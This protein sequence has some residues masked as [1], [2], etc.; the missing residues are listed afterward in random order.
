MKTVSTLLTGGLLLCALLATPALAQAP[1][2]AGQYQVVRTSQIKPGELEL[3][4]KATRDNQAWYRAHG[5]ADR[6][7]VGR[8]IAPLGSDAPFSPTLVMTVHTDM[9]QPG[10]P[11]PHAA[12]D[13]AWA[14]YVAEYRQSSTMAGE[15]VVCLSPAG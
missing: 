5:F 8:V 14:A 6:I 2:C 15:S 13:A 3:F 1:A 9:A 7:L 12:D 10:G 11:A 4:L